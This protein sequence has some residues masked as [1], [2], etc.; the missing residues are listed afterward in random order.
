M[1][2][3]KIKKFSY[4][5]AR[6]DSL[7]GA[8]MKV[9]LLKENLGESN[10]MKLIYGFFNEFDPDSSLVISNGEEAEEIADEC[11]QEEEAEEIADECKQEVEAEETADE[12]KQEV[13]AEETADKS[14]QEVEAEE[15][16][17]QPK[18]DE[19]EEISAINA[20][21]KY[22]HTIPELNRI[23]EESASYQEFVSSIISL[24]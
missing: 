21:H 23:A 1:S 9:Q 3:C 10:K 4:N 17:D 20:R 5:D 19:K 6:L 2:F 15:T 11:K 18:Q 14:K 16:S 13:K 8:T 22:F 12:S 7:V 24:I